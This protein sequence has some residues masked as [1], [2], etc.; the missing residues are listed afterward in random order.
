MDGD[1]GSEDRKAIEPSPEIL[2]RLIA[3]RPGMYLGKATYEHAIG[4]LT[5]LASIA[6]S[7]SSPAST[8]VGPDE[9]SARSDSDLLERISAVER[10]PGVDDREAI[11]A[12]EPLLAEAL[13]ELQ[14]ASAAEHD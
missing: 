7:L 8:G 10:D 1:Y 6:S 13:A 5:G 2:A 9:F 11:L 12:L 14:E 4:L 3:K